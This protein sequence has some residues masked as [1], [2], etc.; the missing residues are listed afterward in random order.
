M[1]IRE[2]SITDLEN[3]KLFISKNIRREHILSKSDELLKWL[4]LNDSGINFILAEDDVKIIAILGFIP[5][6]RFDSSL[7]DLISGSIWAVSEKAPPGIGLLLLKYLFKTYNPM[8]YLSLGISVDSRKI[9]SRL[10]H[11]IFSLNHFVYHA[12]ENFNSNTRFCLEINNSIFEKIDHNY[13]PKKSFDFFDNKYL[14]NPFYQYIIINLDNHSF[15]VGRIIQ[16]KKSKIFRIVDFYGDFFSADCM[17][18]VFSKFI[19]SN[20]LDYIDFF[21]Y[22]LDIS[23][24]EKCGFKKILSCDKYPHYTEP[25]IGSSVE[26]LGA[27]KCDD[28][29]FGNIVINKSDSDQDRPNLIKW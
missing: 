14:S 17:N 9:L 7:T 29:M 8:I 16:L 10:G 28:Q 19:R 13:L 24:L 2:G 18:A 11:R 6:N 25:E 1:E 15:V 26:L 3:I 4:Y 12:K 23:L 27:I 5:N 22:G 20:C 21:N